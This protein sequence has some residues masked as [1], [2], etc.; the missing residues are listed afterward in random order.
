[1]KQHI[2]RAGDFKEFA[3]WLDKNDYPT[4]PPANEHQR[5]QVW[6]GEWYNV[7]SL[8]YAKDRLGVTGNKLE[9]LVRK[10]YNERKLDV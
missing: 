3:Q 4:R 9:R 1:M 8:P 5:L 6:L 2:L 7:H 10:F